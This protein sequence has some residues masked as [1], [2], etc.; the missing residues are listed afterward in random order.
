MFPHD[1]H[2]L[3]ITVILCSVLYSLLL[4]GRSFCVAN[5]GGARHLPCD[6]PSSPRQHRHLHLDHSDGTLPLGNLDRVGHL[7][8]SLRALTSL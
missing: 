2:V 7:V 5:A 8:S 6:L 4:H 3:T 1:A